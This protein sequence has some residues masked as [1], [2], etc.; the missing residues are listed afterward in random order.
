MSALNAAADAWCAA[1][2]E[3]GKLVEGV[4]L[5]DYVYRYEDDDGDGPGEQVVAA[6]REILGARSPRLGLAS[7]DRGLRIVCATCL[8]PVQ[9]TRCRCGDE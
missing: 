2:S 8:A 1:D 7:D 5:G 4:R 3:A 6:A 9:V